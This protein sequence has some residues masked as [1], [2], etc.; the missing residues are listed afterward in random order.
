VSGNDQCR[1][2]E[3]GWHPGW[4]RAFVVICGV[5]AIG[6]L[7]W[8]AWCIYGRVPDAYGE[9]DGA[10]LELFTLHASRGQWALGPYS[11]FGW[12]HPGPF[13]IYLLVP[14]YVASGHHPLALTAGA[15]AI[16][17][18]A[19]G[20]IVWTLCR[21]ASGT[22]TVA[23]VGA[24][25]VYLL[26]VPDVVTSTW[27]PHVL[28]L[29]YAALMVS[30][31]AVASGRLSMLPLMALLATF[32]TQTH[33]GLAPVA[34]AIAGC[35][36]VAGVVVASH[37]AWQ[38]RQVPQPQRDAV[39]ANADAD[40]G[41]VRRSLWLLWK[42]LGVTAVALFVTWLPPLYDEFAGTG[43]IGRLLT[44]FGEKSST[45]SRRDT[46]AIWVGTLL[47]PLTSDF[48][49]A[50]GGAL[51]PMP[52]S[53]IVG[54]VAIGE[55]A[56]LV[57]VSLWAA[58]RGRLVEAW[59]CRL[60]AIA[61]VVAY[62]AIA[63]IRGG[64]VDHLTF[65]NTMTGMLNAAAL[66]GVGLI[67]LGDFVSVWLVQLAPLMRLSQLAVVV[68]LA[69]ALQRAEAR[70]WS[71]ALVPLGCSIAVLWLAS[72]GAV[73]LRQRRAQLIARPVDAAPVGRLYLTTRGAIARARLHRP[74]VEVRGAWAD[75][76]GM[77]V[78][79]DK[80]G[81]P[82][83]VERAAAWLY[84]APIASRGDEDGAVSIAD[85]ANGEVFARNG[86]ECLVAAANGTYVF[87]RASTPEQYL[88]LRCASFQSVRAG[89][90]TAP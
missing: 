32:I 8:C 33:V 43:N 70:R 35:A 44:F 49:T 42:W 48:T 78:Q 40:V 37:V 69:R 51:P 82:V 57:G 22:M 14:F 88:Q 66:L 20:I 64:L 65:W 4:S 6:L 7:I 80:H 21:H 41:R 55:V 16:N 86:D 27:N 77:L 71:A 79:F 15:I 52:R 38:G 74:L 83:G 68:R 75:A 13:Y 2:D 18:A 58:R 5:Y 12:Y 73:T 30:G 84:G 54:W 61:S 47:Q 59:L 45:P 72:H 23:V 17:V 29:P 25:V 34:L 85:A 46:F 3:R 26:R 10:I 67:W 76:A 1:G 90:A 50:W 19:L 56:L 24:L 87:V 89:A 60:S 28:L 53:A 62:L 81:I 11:R 9:G 36:L 39:A 31:A 63:R